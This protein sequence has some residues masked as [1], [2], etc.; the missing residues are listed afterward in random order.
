MAENG[1]IRD[2]HHMDSTA[3]SEPHFTFAPT[4]IRDILQRQISHTVDRNVSALSGLS[5]GKFDGRFLNNFPGKT[6]SMQNAYG[7]FYHVVGMSR[8]G[9]AS[10]A[11]P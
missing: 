2:E 6:Q 1:P 10:V 4:N 3:P 9:D 5:I 11:A 8:G 7:R